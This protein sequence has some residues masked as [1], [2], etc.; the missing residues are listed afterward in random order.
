MKENE[1]YFLM[2]YFMKFKTND[3]II[4]K[5]TFCIVIWLN[6]VKVFFFVTKRIGRI[7]I[8]MGPTRFR[9]FI[10]VRKLMD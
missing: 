8:Q 7:A 3:V 6:D 4:L 10:E 9:E 1:V 5:I 2:I